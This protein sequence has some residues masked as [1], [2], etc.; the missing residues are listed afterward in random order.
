MEVAKSEDDG[1]EDMT[2]V[3]DEITAKEN[4][5]AELRE[6]L[7]NILLSVLHVSLFFFSSS[8]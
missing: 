7:K 5:L 3:D 4:E 8:A 6:F 1:E 2:A